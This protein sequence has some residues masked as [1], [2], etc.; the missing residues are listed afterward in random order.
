MY[1]DSR[2]GAKSVECAV[3]RGLRPCICFVAMAVTNL[4]VPGLSHL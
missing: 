1:V 3:I 4:T 2:R